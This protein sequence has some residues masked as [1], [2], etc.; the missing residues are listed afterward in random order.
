MIAPILHGKVST[1]T[2]SP[3]QTNQ[4]CIID[5]SK[6]REAENQRKLALQHA[7]DEKVMGFGCLIVHIGRY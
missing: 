5:Y 3:R 6:G 1:D 4:S 2:S 7:L